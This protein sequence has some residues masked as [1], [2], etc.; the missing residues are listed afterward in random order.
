MIYYCKYVTGNCF[1]CDPS[2]STFLNLVTDDDLIVCG[3]SKFRPILYTYCFLTQRVHTHSHQARVLPNG[4]SQHL[5]SFLN[6]YVAYCGC[7]RW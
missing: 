2:G 1:L 4:I 3:A 5:K 7:A 6:A